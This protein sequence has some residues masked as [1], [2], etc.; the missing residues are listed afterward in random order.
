MPWFRKGTTVQADTDLAGVWHEIGEGTRGQVTEVRP[1]LFTDRADVT[2]AREGLFEPDVRLRDVPTS[3]LR[4]DRSL[5][6]FRP[7]SNI[8]SDRHVYSGASVGGGGAGGPSGP[9]EQLGIFLFGLI[10]LTA[11]LAGLFY[12]VS[13]VGWK[14]WRPVFERGR[15]FQSWTDAGEYQIP[16][17]LAGLATIVVML[18]FLVTASQ[19]RRAGLVLVVLGALTYV[20]IAPRW[21]YTVEHRHA[22]AAGEL[23][24]GRAALQTGEVTAAPGA[25]A[26]PEL[27]C[28]QWRDVGDDVPFDITGCAAPVVLTEEGQ[29]AYVKLWLGGELK[30]LEQGKAT[31]LC[32]SDLGDTSHNDHMPYWVPLTNRVDPD[33]DG[34]AA[35]F[36]TAVRSYEQSPAMTLTCSLVPADGLTANRSD[37]AGPVLHTY[38][39]VALPAPQWR[40]EAGEQGPGSISAHG[41]GDE[42]FVPTGMYRVVPH[43]SDGVLN[44][45]AD[46][47]VDGAL[48]GTFPQGQTGVVVTDRQ[49][50]VGETLWVWVQAQNGLSGWVSF[51]YLEAA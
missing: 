34:H 40:I 44:V 31:L 27:R 7:K 39:P 12:A 51:R 32:R 5:L 45:R 21:M 18:G 1:G 20:L 2:F 22:L 16:L 46:A 28:E 10:A 29:H 36:V 30:Y 50:Y 15:D 48:I 41:A 3:D 35:Y 26:R 47:G 19:R 33:L 23:A 14:T 43:I 4:S 24:A 49:T 6:G 13:W 37:Y 11:L 38:P 25:G 8:E 17:A 9:G 42:V